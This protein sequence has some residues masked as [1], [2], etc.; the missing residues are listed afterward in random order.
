MLLNAH[1][2]AGITLAPRNNAGNTPLHLSAASN[3]NPLVMV[4]LV[5][6]GWRSAHATITCWSNWARTRTRAMM[7]GAPRCTAQPCTTSTWRWSRCV[8]VL[9][10]VEPN[11]NAQR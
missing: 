4:T 7:T 10:S 3:S 6:A 5:S 2:N 1:R 9:L 11:V 8:S